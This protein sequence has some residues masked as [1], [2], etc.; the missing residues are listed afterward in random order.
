[1]HE[2]V[3]IFESGFKFCEQH[4]QWIA[5]GVV[6]LAGTGLALRLLAGALR[7]GDRLTAPDTSKPKRWR[8]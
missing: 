2:F 5:L 7:A 6:V 8:T 4:W 1:M 3:A